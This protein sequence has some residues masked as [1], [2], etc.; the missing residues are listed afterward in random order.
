M[1]NVDIKKFLDMYRRRGCCWWVGDR[2]LMKMK[3]W[4][5]DRLLMVMG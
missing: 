5:G 3:G 1:K 4:V 2:L